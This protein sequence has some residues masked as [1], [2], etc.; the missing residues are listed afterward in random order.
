MQVIT[1]TVAQLSSSRD[2]HVFRGL[3]SYRTGLFKRLLVDPW[4]ESTLREF[5]VFQSFDDG[6][7]TSCTS[8]ENR[9]HLKRDILLR[10][11]LGIAG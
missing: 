5:N 10:E 2:S 1:I 3:L 7:Y 8:L 4:E 9:L 6:L 11:S